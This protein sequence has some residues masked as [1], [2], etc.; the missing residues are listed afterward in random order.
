MIRDFLSEKSV[1]R[2]PDRFLRQ[3]AE[4]L[5]RADD[6]QIEVLPQAGVDDGDRA[7]LRLSLRAALA[8]AE[9]TGHLVERSL[10]RRQADANET[11]RGAAPIGC[12]QGR[13]AFE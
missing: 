3:R 12:L 10:G 4:V 9:E 7:W 2:R 1:N 13:E 11:C 5:H 6:A 8:S